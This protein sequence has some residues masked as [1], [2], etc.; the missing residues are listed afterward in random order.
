MSQNLFGRIFQMLFLFSAVIS[1]FIFPSSV[2]FTAPLDNIGDGKPATSVVLTLID[3][4]A[5]SPDG[6]IYISHRSKNRVRKIDKNGIIHTVAGDGLAGFRGDNGSA[7]EASLNFPAGLAFD[8]LGNL[9]IADRN[10]H[11][12]RKINRKG[13]ITTI[14]GKGIPDMDGDEGP[15]IEA[16][17]YFPS[18]VACDLKGNLFISDRSN[19]R[20]RKVDLKGII[21]T[22]VGLGVPGF[23]G[24][25][26]PAEDAILKY[27]FGITLDKKGN[28]YI[29]DRGN[30]RIR[31]VDTQGIIKTIAG[32]GY[33]AYGGSYGPATRASLAYPTDVAVDDQ[34]NIYFADRNNNRVRK[35]DTLG[36]VTPLAGTGQS[37]YNGDNEVAAE[38]NLYLPLAIAL[39]HD[40]KMVVVDRSHFRLRS[41]DLKSD[42]V[43]TI[44]GN[45]RS[46]F[47]G[48]QGTALGATLSSPS[49]IAIDS[50]G[51]IL[52][53]DQTHNRIRKIDSRGVI[54]TFAGN[55]KLGNEGD[56]GLARKAALYRPTGLV[57]DSKDQV[58]VVSRFP[59][60]WNI[61][62]INGKGVITRF[63]GIG[64][65]DD[66][67]DGGA[68]KD[69]SFKA[70]RDIA[71]DNKGNIFVADL[72]HIRKIDKN[73]KITSY[74]KEKWN[75][76][77]EETHPNGFAWGP[78]G[79]LYVSD[80]GSN[81]I[82][83]IESTGKMT[84]IAGTGEMKD[85]RD[86]GP[87]IEAGIRSPGGL[88][89]S[90]SGELFIAEEET[91]R[92]RKI[93]IRGI[94]H[95]VAGKGTAGYSGDGGLAIEAELKNPFRLVFDKEGNLYFTDRDNNRIRKIDT[96]GIITTIA[97]HSNIGWMQDGLEV[98]I[99][100]HN[101]P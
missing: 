64:R 80:S 36:I 17:L 66:R 97:G 29:A 8:P 83:R 60:S 30:N 45:G 7:L 47:K 89:F 42:Q 18:D 61:R 72:G 50:R 10:N 49:G 78:D 95:L 100:V 2:A 75:R 53:A 48:D 55:G 20:I 13:I 14:A 43:T 77:N 68:P 34:G 51:N 88:A 99:T 79:A 84:T 74:Y 67:G 85:Q 76:Q 57:I 52:F 56:G 4:V 54:S 38:T 27:P 31:K 40:S 19:N 62:K 16:S 5:V 23:G 86:G 65:L 21:S 39:T 93:D 73:G 11:R 71:T 87:A 96:Q 91:H 26:G 3:G 70:L 22:V 9:Y 44:A 33:H 59:P 81:K 41:I 35:I 32:D 1:F 46:H 69:A 12:I 94:I 58:Y 24:D 37:D 82:R 28:L 101:F 15:A 25:F 6:E 63:A 90:P 98:R 92:I